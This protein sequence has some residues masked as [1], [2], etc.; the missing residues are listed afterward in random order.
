[1][2]CLVRCR[3]RVVRGLVSRSVVLLRLIPMGWFVS[4]RPWARGFFVFGL[5]VGRGLISGW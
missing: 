1:V 3:V 2:R 4:G 5:F